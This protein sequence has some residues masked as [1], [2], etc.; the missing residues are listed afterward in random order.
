MR[1]DTLRSVH[2]LQRTRNTGPN[3]TKRTTY[4]GDILNHISI[5]RQIIGR[6]KNGRA[7]SIKTRIQDMVL[8]CVNKLCRHKQSSESSWIYETE[9]YSWHLRFSQRRKPKYSVITQNTNFDK[10]IAVRMLQKHTTKTDREG[11]VT[12]PVILGPPHTRP[13]PVN[14]RWVHCNHVPRL[15]I[16]QKLMYVFNRN[17]TLA[18]KT[19]QWS[20]VQSS[21]IPSWEVTSQ[22]QQTGF[23]RLVL[24]SHLW[25]SGCCQLQPNLHT[26]WTYS[27]ARRQRCESLMTGGPDATGL[28]LTKTSLI[29]NCASRTAG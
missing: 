9:G 29:W 15:W 27:S 12:L 7:T 5:Y 23:F 24:A 14:S 4:L 17:V 21:R 3:W 6:M 26:D 16:R 28:D 10:S 11:K 22:T 19:H 25:Q 8:L 1:T 2:I 13:S 18:S 20:P